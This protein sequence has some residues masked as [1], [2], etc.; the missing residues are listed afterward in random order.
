MILVYSSHSCDVISHI[1]EE[2]L[3]WELGW[4]VTLVE[5]KDKLCDGLGFFTSPPPLFD[6][7]SA[8]KTGGGFRREH[9]TGITRVAFSSKQ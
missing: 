8:P 4:P 9:A 3:V 2:R 6:P 7:L 5:D 1:S